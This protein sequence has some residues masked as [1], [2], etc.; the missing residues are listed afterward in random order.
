VF[1]DENP[2]QAYLIVVNRGPL[3][4]PSLSVNRGA[5]RAQNEPAQQQTQQPNQVQ[6]YPQ[7]QQPQQ[8]QPSK[9]KQPAFKDLL[10]KF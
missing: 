9:K 7:Q 6:Q 10:K 3:D 2:Q 4:D 1:L 5:G 8:Q